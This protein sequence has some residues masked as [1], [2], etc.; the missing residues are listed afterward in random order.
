MARWTDDSAVWCGSQYWKK[1]AAM[2]EIC[3]KAKCPNPVHES[4]PHSLTNVYG[5]HMQT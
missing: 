3:G 2:E 4:K 1:A 5:F